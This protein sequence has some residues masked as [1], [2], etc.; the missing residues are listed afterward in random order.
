MA[1]EETKVIEPV[2]STSAQESKA[3]PTT[4]KGKSVRARLIPAKVAASWGDLDEVEGS[5]RVLLCAPDVLSRCRRMLGPGSQDAATITLIKEQASD[6]GPFGG[7][8]EADT[9]DTTLDLA[10]IEWDTLP[11]G[12]VVIPTS[13]EAFEG[14]GV[15]GISAAS[16]GRKQ[17]AKK[18]R[19]QL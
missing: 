19:I 1:K 17:K 3:T 2:A 12:S 4:K 10:L 6:L 5:G 9:E 16:G 14:W 18:S 7:D 15:V 11:D 8:A 13:E